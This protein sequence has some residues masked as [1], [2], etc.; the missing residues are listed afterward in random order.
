MVLGVHMH[1]QKHLK[2]WEAELHKISNVLPTDIRC[3]L[4]ISYDSLDQQEKNIFLDTACFFRGKDRDTAI[5]I[6]DGSDWEGELSFRNLQNRCLLEINHK[7][8]IRMHDH[9]R[10]LGRDLAEKEPPD[11]WRRIWRPTDNLIYQPS[12]VSILKI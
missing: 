11:C 5:R 1:G 9:L 2:Y 10:D 12:P 3:R 4:K 8:E 6:W 7:N